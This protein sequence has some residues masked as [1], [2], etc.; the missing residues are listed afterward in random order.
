MSQTQVRP[1]RATH[2]HTRGELVDE[3]MHVEQSLR[4][5]PLT[6]GHGTTF[7]PELLSLASREYSIICELADQER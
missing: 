5:V 1:T 3:L 4:T 7:S 6:A 2:A